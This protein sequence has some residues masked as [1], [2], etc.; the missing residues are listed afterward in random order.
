MSDIA[1]DFAGGIAQLVAHL[2]ELGHTQ[3]GF[4]GG[5]EGLVT[6]RV[7]RTCFLDSVVNNGLASRAEWIRPANFTVESGSEAMERILAEKE[8]PS[9]IL[10]ANDLTAI[11]ALR[12]AHAHGLNVPGDISVAG[13]DD[14]AMADI[15]YPPL[16][17]LR[18]SRKEYARLL[19]KALSEAGQDLTKPGQQFTLPLTL[20]VR[21]STG[22]A[23]G[24]GAKGGRKRAATKN[25]L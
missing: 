23:P 21:Q 16:T 3:L 2:K 8:I 4:I 18:I 7:R 15:V 14:I 6:S 1:V 11:G 17:T 20:V 5:T 9:A 12:T 19:Y 22:P 24:H 25:K 13:C 10:C